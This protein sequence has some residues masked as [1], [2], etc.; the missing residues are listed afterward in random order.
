MPERSTN[1]QDLRAVLQSSTIQLTNSTSPSVHAMMV[2]PVTVD[3]LV[4]RDDLG[5]VF[6]Y[7]CACV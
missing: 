7:L 5:V 1:V 6:L 4:A 2:F 3:S